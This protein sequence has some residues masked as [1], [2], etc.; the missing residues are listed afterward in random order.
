MAFFAA[1]FLPVVFCYYQQSQITEDTI[2]LSGLSKKL[3]SKFLK[4]A[5]GEGNSDFKPGQ[6]EPA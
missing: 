5:L 3:V 4:Y 6:M 2:K 1:F